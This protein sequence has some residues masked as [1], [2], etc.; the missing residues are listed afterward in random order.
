ME[1]IDSIILRLQQKL[2]DIEYQRNGLTD[3]VLNK[4]ININKKRNKLNIP[5]PTE[6]LFEDYYVQ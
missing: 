3:S 2:V 1:K 4:Q 5:D 6:K